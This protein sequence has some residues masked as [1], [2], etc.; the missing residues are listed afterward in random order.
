MTRNACER[1]SGWRA[2]IGA[3]QVAVPQARM[4][5]HEHHGRL[6]RGFPLLLIWFVMA[7]SGEATGPCRL[8][9]V[10]NLPVSL[11]RGVVE[12]AGQVIPRLAD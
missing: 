11:E 2:P 12:V 10:A 5:M 3:A 7:C 1:R 6:F 9:P 4:T 8:Q